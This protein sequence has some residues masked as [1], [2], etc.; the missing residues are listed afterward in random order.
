MSCKRPKHNRYDAA[1]LL[2]RL[3]LTWGRQFGPRGYHFGEFVPLG[4]LQPH[5]LLLDGLQIAVANTM[6]N[7]NTT[8]AVRLAAPD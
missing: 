6:L 4:L 8:P 3:G 2:S 1:C 5:R 7:K